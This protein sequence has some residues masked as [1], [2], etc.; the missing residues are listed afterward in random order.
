MLA[1]GAVAIGSAFVH[2]YPALLV[3]RVMLGLAEGGTLVRVYVVGN[4]FFEVD[5]Y[6]QSGL[7]Y[8][9][10]RV[11]WQRNIFMIFDPLGFEQYYRRSELVLRI[12]IFFG[13]SPTLAGA[14][15]NALFLFDFRRDVHV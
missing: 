2:S 6:F 8:I 10:A 14:C 12:G 7:V 15:K 4:E 5:V 3:T 9:L 1:F 11:R 13:L